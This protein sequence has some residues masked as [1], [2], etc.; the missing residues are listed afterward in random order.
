ME[1]YIE[2]EIFEAFVFADGRC[3]GMLRHGWLRQR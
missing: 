3:Y 1:V 2:Y